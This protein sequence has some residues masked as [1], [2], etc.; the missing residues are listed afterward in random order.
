MSGVSAW[1]FISCKLGS[2]YKLLFP[3]L[4]PAEAP[5]QRAHNGTGALRLH[6][7]LGAQ[8]LRVRVVL[9]R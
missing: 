9:G 8:W 7:P 2:F 3:Y 1:G 4:H 5:P 6:G